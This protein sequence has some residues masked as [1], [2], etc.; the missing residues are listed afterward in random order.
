MRIENIRS[1]KELA[2]AISKLVDIVEVDGVLCV[3]ETGKLAEELE[4]LGPEPRIVGATASSETYE[5]LARSGFEALQLPIHGIDKYRQIPHVLSVALKSGVMLVGD[6]VL[7]AL[8]EHVYP[9]EGPLL[10]LGEVEKQL[11]DLSI[12]DLLKLT[13]GIRPT[14]LDAT[15]EVAREI[16]R[17]TCTKK[18]I[19]TIFTLGDSEEVLKW[20]EQ[21]IPNPFKGQGGSGHKITDPD[22]QDTLIELAKLDGGFVIRGDGLIRSVGTY[23]RARYD[24]DQEEILEIRGKL[25]LPEGLGSR[26]ISAAAITAC[27]EATA[28]VVSE[29]D[30]NIRVFAGGEMVLKMDPSIEYKPINR[31]DT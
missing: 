28:V 20:S 15:I 29:T 21:L 5:E 24:K 17:L 23:L 13:D 2:K 27:T 25:N 19:G 1:D 3:T 31:R 11:E 30:G 6:L 12:K 14:V 4:A 18:R 16:G 9:E 26:H 8:G 7:V 22:I 10:V